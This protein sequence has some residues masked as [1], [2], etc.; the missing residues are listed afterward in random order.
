MGCRPK[1]SP[2]SDLQHRLRR[3]GGRRRG[4]STS[5]AFP[6]SS[7]RRREFFLENAGIFSFGGREDREA[8]TLPSCASSSPT[9]ASVSP[10]G[11]VRSR[12]TGAARLTGRVGKWSLGVLGRPDRR[13]RENASGHPLPGTGNRTFGRGP[14]QAQYLGPTL[15]RW[16]DLHLTADEDGDNHNRVY[17]PNRRRLESASTS[18]INL[19]A[20][21]RRRAS[22]TTPIDIAAGARLRHAGDDWDSGGAAFGFDGRVNSRPV[23]KPATR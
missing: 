11:D 9:P 17:G 20:V 21:L 10:D 15:E 22:G 5:P 13:P 7:R 3:G 19:N 2:G 4:E 1:L 14:G 18:K 16:H 6:S 8:S 23:S 12:S